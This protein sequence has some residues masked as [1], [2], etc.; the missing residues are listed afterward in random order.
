MSGDS[1]G[2][3]QKLSLIIGILTGLILLS[4]YISPHMSA[5]FNTIPI[6]STFMGDL[7]NFL[8]SISSIIVAIIIYVVILIIAFIL[9]IYYKETYG[10]R[11]NTL[12]FLIIT[13]TLICLPFAALWIWIYSSTVTTFYIILFFILYLIIANIF[14]IG[15]LIWNILGK[16]QENI[17]KP[18]ISELDDELIKAIHTDR[19]D[20][21]LL[22]RIKS[23]SNNYRQNAKKQYD[24]WSNTSTLFKDSY[25]NSYEKKLDY[26]QKLENTRIRFIKK[27]INEDVFKNELKS[28]YNE[29]KGIR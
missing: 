18:Y 6:L 20:E 7:I 14:V 2:I 19:S 16:A 17:I 12:I 21:S 27:Q 15:D 29:Y 25:K 9:F 22:E 3:L 5:V 28:L 8:S 26:I 1:G 10:D 4:Q 13:T 24:Y 11:K 23:D